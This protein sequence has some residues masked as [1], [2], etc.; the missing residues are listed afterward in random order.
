MILRRMTR[1]AAGALLA[2]AAIL[3]AAPAFAGPASA[4]KPLAKFDAVKHD[5]GKVKQGDVLTHEF[6]FKN[7]GENTLVVDRVETTCGCTAALVSANKIEPGKEGKVKVS[8][9][10]RGY[11]GRLVK[12]VFME[13]NDS[14][15]ARRE[16]TISADIEV[17]PSP[18]IELDRYNVEMGLG[19]EGE[20]ASTR[21]QVKNV[22]EMELAADMG[23]AEMQ[24]LVDGKPVKFP[25]KIAAGKSADVEI[26]I[27]PSQRT[28]ALSD[29]ILVKSNDPVRS[30]LSIYV[31]RYVVTRKELRE[32]FTKYRKVLEEK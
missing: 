32:L 15:D 18:K 3:S 22:G 21:V 1:P 19:L 31:R 12:Y 20:P 26:R 8:F 14:G 30:T 10:T 17:P 11:S 25:L 5:F 23:H 4:A 27:P 24:F 6:T 9:D 2:I 7:V 13:S 16:L 29:Y 28:G